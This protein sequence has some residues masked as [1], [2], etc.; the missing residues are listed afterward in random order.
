MTNKKLDFAAIA[1]RAADSV[2]SVCK[3]WLPNGKRAGHEWEIGDRFGNAGQSL[4]VHLSG[5][6]AGQWAD[7]AAGDTGGDLVALVAYVEGVSQGEAAK[8]LAVFLGMDTA[9]DKQDQNTRKPTKPR[10]Q[11]AAANTPADTPKPPEWRAL[12]PVPADAPE[13]PKAHIRHGAPDVI[14][15]Y[16]DAAGALLGYVARWEANEKRQKKEFGWLIYTERAGVREWRWA[17]FPA[18][19]PLYGL[20]MLAKDTHASVLL[21]EG[22][23]AAEAARVLLPVHVVLTWPG[24][25]KAA[26]KADFRPLKGRDVLLW[27]DADTPGHAAMQTAE[28]LALKAGAASVQWLNLKTLEATRNK[29]ELQQ[30]YDAADMLAEGWD[31]ERL[32]AL[33]KR[34]DAITKP[35]ATQPDQGREDAEESRFA[36]TDAG[37]FMRKA[38]RDGDVR[39]IRLSDPL[40]APALARDEEGGGWAPVLVFRDRDGLKRQEIIPFRQFVG[41]GADGVK[42]LAD[43]GLAIEPGRE[44]IDGLKQY[45]AGSHPKKR[46]RLADGLGWHGNAYLFPDGAVGEAGEMLIY[47][48][49]KRAIGVFTPRGS[50]Q[51][52]QKHIAALALGNPRLMFTLSAAFAGI[53]L[54]V[55]GGASSAFHWVGDSSLGKSGCLHAAASV[56]GN[57]ADAVHSWRHTDNALEYTAAQHNDGL[58]ILDELKE[59]DPRQAQAISYMLGNGK[60][61]GRAHHAGGLREAM[62]WRITMLSS[63]ELGLADHIAST[64]QKSHAGQA[65]RFIELPADAGAGLGMWNTLHGMADGA[66]FTNALKDN[67]GRYYGT[68]ARAFIAAM[69]ENMEAVPGVVKRLDEAFQI[70]L[71]PPE[72][73]GQVKRVA[74]A[75]AMVAAAGALA[76]EWGVCPWPEPRRPV[77]D[78]FLDPFDAAGAMFKAW[79]NERPTVRNLEEAQILAHVRKLIEATMYGRFVDFHRAGENTASEL[80]HMP[81]V[82]NT[83]GFRKRAQEWTEDNR[84]YLFYITKSAFAGEF[85][86]SG[87]FKPRRVAQVLKQYGVLRCDGENLTWKEQLPNGDSRSHCIIGRKLWEI[88]PYA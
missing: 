20:D 51:D 32:A 40:H 87:G 56:W 81:A 47:R 76:V 83:L 75:F 17:G 67:G 36:V 10:Q 1:S 29:G 9:Q 12:M 77:G 78:S 38:G 21:V 69:I 27:P 5:T 45:I 71:V 8:R 7:F 70:H 53:L 58:L 23:K 42:Q 3:H 33:L 74:S 28:R 60:G 22:E 49:S 24:G 66:A 13:P 59:V 55:C 85:A 73:S 68:A 31:V 65:V 30:G 41:D 16:R 61:K 15:T 86:A 88:E 39:L 43:L 2:E 79:L 46:A 63:G 4:K 18:P 48:G 84:Q 19:R 34:P 82:H 26:D 64:G 25:G 72:A 57:P 52:W 80:S 14:Y 54:R 44:A 50:L 11:G 37:L 6:K 35:H 62:S